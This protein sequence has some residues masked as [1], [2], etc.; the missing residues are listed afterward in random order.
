MT[1]DLGKERGRPY[2]IAARVAAVPEMSYQLGYDLETWID[3]G[4]VDILVPAG[5]A[6]TDP[7]PA[8]EKFLKM[9]EG[10]DIVVYPGFDA[11]IDGWD[12]DHFVGPEP[13]A[14]SSCCEWMACCRS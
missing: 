8:V 5:S 9:C 13:A 11:R 6:H 7:D 10:T 2:Y 4:L 1:D 3:E 14:D 12:F